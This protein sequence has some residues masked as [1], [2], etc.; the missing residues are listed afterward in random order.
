MCKTPVIC[1]FLMS[2]SLSAL[3]V[4]CEP[5]PKDA[6]KEKAPAATTGSKPGSTTGKGVKV[7]PSPSKGKAETPKAAAPQTDV[8]PETEV[9]KEGETPKTE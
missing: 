6:I 2:F 9:P 4:G 1:S 8:K 7:P 5:A 3:I